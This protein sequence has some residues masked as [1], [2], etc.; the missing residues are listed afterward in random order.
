MWGYAIRFLLFVCLVAFITFD[1]IF[2]DQ[3]LIASAILSLSIQQWGGKPLE[4]I[5]LLFTTFFAYITLPIMYFH[6]VYAKNQLLA[7]YYFYVYGLATMIGMWLKLAFYKGRPYVINQGLSGSTCDPGMPSGH[8]IIAVCGYYA[9][10]QI[11]ARELYP[12]HKTIKIVSMV[13]CSLIALCI[14]VSRIT[15]GDHGYNQVIMGFL[16]GINVIANVSFDG[17]CEYLMKVPKCLKAFLLPIEVFN[18]SYLILMIAINHYFREDPT[19]WKYM[20]KNPACK[21]TF[22]VGASIA[23]PFNSWFIGSFLYYP[24]RRKEPEGCAFKTVDTWGKFWA[25]MGLHL[26]VTLPLVPL[27]VLG[28]FVYSS[29]LEIFWKAAII[30]TIATIG[31]NYLAFA[32]VNLSKRVFEKCGVAIPRDY[33]HAD[34]RA[35]LEAE[36]SYVYKT[37]ELNRDYPH[38][39][40]SSNLSM[41]P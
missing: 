22:V 33:L 11:V 28:S 5:G 19:L 4:I 37:T 41:S 20:N 30:A 12:N 7:L 32:M 38:M 21:G 34:T 29:D 24:Y 14:M 39:Y 40:L 13:V 36:K 15:L 10:H 1:I 27:F 23:A 2:D 31:A 35:Q 17:F 25:R 18:F 8:S 26:A 3:M 6:F 16:I 9:I